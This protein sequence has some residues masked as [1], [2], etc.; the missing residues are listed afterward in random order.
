M[1]VLGQ[2]E[3]CVWKELNFNQYRGIPA[4][5]LGVFTNRI[6]PIL[7]TSAE[8][9]R[10]GLIRCYETW[11]LLWIV[12]EYTN[13]CITNNM[14]LIYALLCM[15]L[16]MCVI[17]HCLYIL[18]RMPWDVSKQIHDFNILIFWSSISVTFISILS[19]YQ[20]WAGVKSRY[21]GR[22]N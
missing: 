8:P 2:L 11:L 16:F 13:T 17:V 18:V 3:I 6:G 12:I 4:E 22:G 7:A 19:P 1:Y 21:Q 15:P 5:L 20:G 14:L 10:K 9:N